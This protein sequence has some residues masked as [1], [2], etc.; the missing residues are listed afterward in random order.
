MSVKTVIAHHPYE[1]ERED[2][3]SF[4]K[5]E[6]IKVTDFSDPDWWVGKKKDGSL[7]FFPSN[8]VTVLQDG[9]A[10]TEQPT[11]PRVKQSAT[12]D[13]DVEEEKESVEKLNDEQ[14]HVEKEAEESHIEEPKTP[15]EEPKTPVE[16]PKTSVEEKKADKIIGMARVMEDYAMQ[17]Q[18]ELSLHRGGIV[19]VYEVIDDEWSRGELNGK[20]GKYPH[21]FVEDID[22]PGRP[23]LGIQSAD[24]QNSGEDDAP[25]GGFKLA[26]FGVKQGGIGS[27][28]AGGFPG[29]KK[30]PAKADS[31]AKVES[32]PTPTV[33]VAAA[34]SAATTPAVAPVSPAPTTNTLTTTTLPKAIVL[35]PYDAEGEDELSLLR[36]EYVDIIDR[37]ADEGWWKGRNER[38][39]VGVFPV[40]FVRELEEESLAPP[41]PTRSRRS[42]QSETV[43]RPASVQAPVTTRPI[44]VQAPAQRPSSISHTTST[45][46]SIVSP[47]I[48]EQ[49]KEE[50]EEAVEE[51]GTDEQEEVVVKEK[52]IEPAPAIVQ[53]VAEKPAAAAAAVEPAEKPAA[54]PVTES[55]KE[56]VTKDVTKPIVEPATE[57]LAA[58]QSPPVPSQSP[59][60]PARATSFSGEESAKPL[61]EHVDQSSSDTISDDEEKETETADDDACEKKEEKGDAKEAVEKFDDLPTGGPKLTTPARARIGRARRSPQTP[62][63]EPSQTEI[64]EKELLSQEDVKE[65][66]ENVKEEVTPSPPAKP[67]KPIFAKFPTPFAVGGDVLSKA[68]L[69]PTQ[70]RRLWEEK[71]NEAAPTEEAEQQPVRPS[72][73]KNIASRFNFS[74][75]NNSSGGNEVL[76]TKLKNHTKN[77]V[78]RVRKECEQLVN[79][80]REKRVA[81]E[82]I[83]QDL[84]ERVKALEQ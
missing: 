47:R 71:A 66:A 5:E 53:P 11:R 72:G 49:V 51:E 58:T 36:G 19:N 81:L 45:N 54:E 75:G 35:H 32:S 7:G 55:A 77:E 29:L 50:D 79:E 33:P 38:G 67:V 12:T 22:M 31:S 69:K 30:T 17:E 52:T 84:L 63:Q 1:A 62:S 3:I 65:E 64:L 20:I 13:K 56:S 74:G 43:I 26:A 41:T 59:P 60:V 23:D 4:E 27:L 76:E 37:H 70:T 44:S 57:E 18:G 8:F 2:E 10:P 9:D 39:L 28:L 78:E 83:V 42:V 25:K 21:K 6:V 15:V 48:S 24:T 40:N 14:E 80:E 82:Q 68:H 73:V 16:E 46:H 34:A 61:I